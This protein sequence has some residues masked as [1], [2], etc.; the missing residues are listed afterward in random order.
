LLTSYH[1][2]EVETTEIL[3]LTLE[4]PVSQAYAETQHGIG[5]SIDRVLER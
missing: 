3:L 5:V 1:S 2:G 4:L